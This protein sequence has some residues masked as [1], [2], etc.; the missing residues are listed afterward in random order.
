[1]VADFRRRFFV[2]LVLSVP[3]IVLAPMLQELLGVREV[4]AFPGDRWLSAAF[5]TVVFFYGGWPFL[6][7]LASELRKAAPGMMTLIAIA[8]TAAYAYSIATV[9]G[10]QGEGFFWELVTLIDIMLVGH[11]IEM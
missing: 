2:S 1:M 8:I 4:L 9:L 10:L 3:V 5:S 7:G 11:W 6:K